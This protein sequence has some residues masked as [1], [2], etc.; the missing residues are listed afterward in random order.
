MKIF[1]PMLFVGLGG[2]GGLIGAELER[3]LRA[4][5]CGPDG[6]ALTGSGGRLP[7]EL[8]SCLQFVYADYS[9]SELA[10]LPHLSADASLRQA[11]AR[12]ARATHDLLPADF[13]SS[14]EVTRMLRAILREEVADW[15]P[16]HSGEPKVTPLK[17]GAGQ[18]PTVGRAALF[19]T[20]RNGPAPVVAPLHRA[21]DAIA[22]SGGELQEVGGGTISGCDV[23]VAFSVAGG[24]G[25][26]IFLDYLHL[27]G[28]AFKDKRFKGARIYPLVVMPSAFPEAKGGGR[29]AELN[30]ARAVVDLSRLVDEQNAPDAGTEL[31]DTEQQESLRI[32]YPQVHPVSL[33]PG[34]VPTAF[35]FSPTAGIRPDDLRRSIVSLVLSLVGTDVNVGDGKGGRDDDFQTFAATFVNGDVSRRTRSA[36]GIGRQ[37]IST[38]LVASMTAPLDELAELVAARMLAQAVQR[39]TDTTAQGPQETAPLVREMFTAAGLG[40][41][42][43]RD[44]LEVPD[45]DPLPRGSGEIENALRNRVEEMRR[46]LADLERRVAHRMPTLVESFAPRSAAEQLLHQVDLFTLDRVIAGVPGD[47]E[48]VAKLGF[49]GMLDNR[50][51]DPRRPRGVDLQP[52]SVPRIR[53]RAGGLSRPRWGDD[54][55]AAVIADQDRWYKWRARAVWHRAWNEQEPRWRQAAVALQNDA[56]ALGEAF[57]KHVDDQPRAYAAQVKE[58]YDDRTGVSYL[59]PPQGNL[60]RFY[61]ALMERLAESD[62]LGP[63]G[64]EAALLLKL[65]DADL[66]RAAFATARHSPPAAVSEVKAALKHRIQRLF[67][68]RPGQQRARALLPRMGTLLSA[69]AGDGE[70]VEQVSKRALDQFGYKLAGLLP[71]AFTPEGNGRLKVLITYP[72][73]QSRVAVEN[74]LEKELRLP[75][76]SRRTIEFR[77]VD[78]DSITVVLF[79][80]EMSLTEVPEARKVLRQW[81]RAQD[82]RRDDDVL[83]WRQ[84]LGHRDHWLAS[85]AE[86]R[87]HILHRLLCALWNG[88]VD[89]QGDPASPVRLR[90]RLHDDRSS[91]APGIQLRLDEY[92]DGVSSW[93]G[94]LRAYERWALLAE[95]NIVQSYCGVVMNVLPHGLGTSGSEPSELYLKLVHEVAPR[96]LALLDDRERR[97]GARVAEWVRPLR[98]F[99]ADTLPGALDLPF[100]DS[101][102]VAHPSL[103]ELEEWM[104]EG[105]TQE[106][107]PYD[108]GGHGTRDGWD[109]APSWDPRPSH[110]SHVTWDSGET[111]HGPRRPSPPPGRG[112]DPWDRTAAAGTGHGH[113]GT[114]PPARSAP[115]GYPTAPAAGSARDTSAER[116][117]YPG[118]EYPGHEPAAPPAG[119]PG[120]RRPSGPTRLRPPGADRTAPD[121][122]RAD[123]R[124][125]AQAAEDSDWPEPSAPGR[126]EPRPRPDRTATGPDPRTAPGPRGERY[127]DRP[128][129]PWPADRD[130]A[131]DPWGPATDDVVP[132][133]PPAGRA[134]ARP[135]HAST[136]AAAPAGRPAMAPAA[137]RTPDY[138]VYPHE[139]EPD[140][141]WPGGGSAAPWGVA[142]TDGEADWPDEDSAPRTAGD[143]PENWEDHA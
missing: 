74:H 50:R 107:A 46:L 96:Q 84:R 115:G 9:E 47:P 65:V 64:D 76:D 23:F 19:A 11:Y 73:T 139:T 123:G 53:G 135:A 138:P 70:A 103:R 55:V 24:T 130:G 137:A 67:A 119:P 14:P 118:H 134:A 15:L 128:G 124:Y 66:R 28:Q 94:L 129:E 97:Y 63:N 71:A 3:R 140:A 29:E 35:L 34:T 101:E 18:L 81:A 85:T 93:A 80:S 72:G 108:E 141:G 27:I 82:S 32:R 111:D 100:P 127:P 44:P 120:T 26:G 105:R 122:P 79:R 78:T 56:R 83:R 60:G 131:P 121:A 43:R 1:Q 86:D 104:R 36:T 13:E 98:E 87:R 22:G 48:E 114:V 41:L 90:I 39:L 68:E 33:R 6:T 37:G 59:L 58:L 89:F 88:Q 40:E 54:E 142:G 17:N 77:A 42:W 49:L 51:Q 61:Q 75:G 45:P 57:Q 69:A 8:P 21:I 136:P 95:E 126:T 116:G 113:P 92:Q 38:S 125:G 109:T 106:R 16:P 133:A 7:Y 10:R 30:A 20:L 25:A 12:T 4:E 52:P 99:W 91:D 31:G 5:L 110:D 117:P 112:G 102:Q 2:T 62:Q 132:A 143:G